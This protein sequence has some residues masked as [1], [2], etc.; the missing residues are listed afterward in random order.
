M[1]RPVTIRSRIASKIQT[2]QGQ[3]PLL[4]LLDLLLFRSFFTTMTVSLVLDLDFE[5]V[6]DLDRDR[7]FDLDRDRRDGV[8]GDH[9]EVQPAK[10]VDFVAR[11]AGDQVVVP[12]SGVSLLRGS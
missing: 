12:L 9:C 8:T 5:R 7:V 2:Q 10:S 3:Q 6:R 11:L 4:D 1:K